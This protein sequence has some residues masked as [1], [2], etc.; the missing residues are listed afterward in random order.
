MSVV[1]TSIIMVMIRINVTILLFL[2]AIVILMTSFI[3]ISLYE[4]FFV[5]IRS[6]CKSVCA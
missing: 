2:V 4:A 1:I 3:M 5:P 6:I